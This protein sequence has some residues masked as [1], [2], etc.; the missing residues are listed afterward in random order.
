M[1]PSKF[2]DFA[3]AIEKSNAYIT[4][5]ETDCRTGIGR[6]MYS[7]FL[8]YREEIGNKI[9]AID[10]ILAAKYRN[11]ITSR[12]RDKGKI[13]GIIPDI[14]MM[15]NPVLRDQYLNLREERNKADYNLRIRLTKRDLIRANNYARTLKLRIS[16]IRQ[17]FPQKSQ[18]SNLFINYSL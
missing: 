10:T 5:E 11:F 13:H 16:V 12:R 18:I 8:E 2:F 1:D 14:L 17:N 6:A 9:Q 3:E 15:C 4:D 7:I